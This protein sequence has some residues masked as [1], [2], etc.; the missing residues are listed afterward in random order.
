MSSKNRYRLHDLYGISRQT[1]EHFYLEEITS[2]AQVAEMTPAELRRFK[3]IG[4]VKAVRI[5]AHAQA[6]MTEEAVWHAPLPEVCQ[7]PGIMLDIETE[8][9]PGRP[10]SFGWQKPGEAVQITVVAPHLHTGRYRLPDGHELILVKDYDAAW[11]LIAEAAADVP[12]PI[13]HWSKYEVGVLRQSASRGL[14][15]QLEPRLHDLLETFQQTVAPPV[16]SFSIKNIGAYLGIRWPDGED[17]YAAWMGY[18]QWQRQGEPHGLA[19]GCAYLRSDVEALTAAWTW[20]VSSQ[21]ASHE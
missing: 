7:Q 11:G 21:R 1:L 8:F 15:A 20:I 5:R 19:T 17:A 2:L 16:T 18:L 6:L 10:W 14:I 4:Q 13:Y 12:G 3:G 9:D